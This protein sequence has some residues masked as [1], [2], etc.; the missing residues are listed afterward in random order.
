M[1]TYVRA[2][3]HALDT[4]TLRT[5]YGVSGYRLAQR[6]G[7]TRETLRK[8]QRIHLVPEG[9][10]VPRIDLE[11]AA[12]IAAALGEDVRDLFCHPNGDPIE[13]A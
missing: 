10:D 8:Q 11:L 13:S 9:Q 12:R 4:D 1:A 6:A 2:R 3:A 5:K 7:I